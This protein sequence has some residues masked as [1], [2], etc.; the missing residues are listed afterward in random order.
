MPL[1]TSL[2]PTYRCR[3]GPLQV[4]NMRDYL[5]LDFPRLATFNLRF[6]YR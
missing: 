6:N 4:S 2:C 1:A 5:P 3:W